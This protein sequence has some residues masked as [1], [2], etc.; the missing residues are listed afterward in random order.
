MIF[1]SVFFYFLLNLNRINRALGNS[2]GWL[3]FL[4]FQCFF[5]WISIIR[6]TAWSTDL[7]SIILYSLSLWNKY[8]NLLS[9][10]LSCGSVSFY[11]F[12]YFCSGIMGLKE[13]FNTMLLSSFWLFF[14]FC[15]F[16]VINILNIEI[17]RPLLAMISIESRVNISLFKL[18]RHELNQFLSND[19]L[20]Q[21]NSFTWNS[22]LMNTFT[23]LHLF[24]LVVLDICNFIDIRRMQ[25]NKFLS[26]MF[27]FPSMIEELWIELQKLLEMGNIK[28]SLSGLLDNIL[29]VCESR[30]HT[31]DK[32]HIQRLIQCSLKLIQ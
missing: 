10:L 8:W 25:N 15:Q 18:I 2:V 14:Q 23:C 9:L 12:I 3:V 30:G 13:I 20:S 26:A 6:I 4:S 28:L 31:S 1:F 21:F 32:H 24:S 17:W 11:S 5:R 16:N 27:H 7:T 22:A 19:L 29:Q